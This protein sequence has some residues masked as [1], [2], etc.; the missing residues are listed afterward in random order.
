M[1]KKILLL[2]STLLLIILY[3][4]NGRTDG[5]PIII[6]KYYQESTPCVCRYYY[7]GL[8]QRGQDFTDSYKKY[9]IGDTIK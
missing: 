3:S 1:K 5:R 9:N 6:A 8:D 2:S 7:N 4:C